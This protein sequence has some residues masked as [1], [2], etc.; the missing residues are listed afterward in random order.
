[1]RILNEIL[2]VL[3][4]FS[5]LAE[6]NAQIV[7]SA[8]QD[9]VNRLLYQHTGRNAQMMKM[10]GAILSMLAAAV[11]GCNS[12]SVSNSDER[13][14]VDG[15]AGKVTSLRVKQSAVKSNPEMAPAAIVAARRISFVDVAEERGLNYQWPQQPRPMTAL[16]AF[17]A[18]CAAFDGD[19]DGWQDVL[20]ACDPYPKLYQN[21]DGASFNDVTQASGLTAADGDWMGCATGDYNGDGLLDVL[22]TGYHRLALYKNVGGLRF[23][24]ATEEAGLDPLNAGHWGSGA[25]FMDLDGDQCLDVV[26]LNYVVFGPESKQYCEHKPGVLS[27]CNPRVTYPP[28]RGGIWRNTGSGRFE[29]VPQSHGMDTTHG[30]GLVL[31]FIDLDDDGLIDF[32]IGNDG[33]PAELMHNLGDMRFEN[34]AKWAG[35]AEADRGVAAA[36]GADWADYDVDGLQDLV[37]TDWEGKGSTLFQGMGSNVFLNRSQTTGLTHQTA[38]RMGF[39]TKWVDFENDGWPDIFSVNGHVYDNSAEINGPNSPFRQSIS[40]LSNHTGKQF[41]DIVTGF[42]EDVQRAIVGRG[43]ATADFDNDGRLDLLAVDFEGPVML[44]MNRTAATHH[45]ITLDLRGAAHNVFAYG[46]HV[47]GK[48][49]ERIWTSDVSPASSYLSSSDLRIHWG[50]GDSSSLDSITIRWPSGAKQTLTDV[51]AD[52][53]LRVVEDAGLH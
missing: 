47:T 30:M 17:G 19:N 1:M 25:G 4:R 9:F 15:S 33:T 10:F 41:V 6:W 44:M 36:M 34:I 42:G 50:L 7:N 3:R 16:H 2:R 5:T 31:A 20:L 46:A 29:P 37:I 23:E 39:G 45:W 38:N 49:G 27:G 22:L 26:I 32:Y 48:V 35:V 14:S 52:Q 28:E 13:P 40:L 24:L 18:G 8:V 53:I 21:I 11:P 12:Q 43:S 51:A